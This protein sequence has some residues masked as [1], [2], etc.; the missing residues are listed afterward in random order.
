MRNTVFIL[1]TTVSVFAF[2][3]LGNFTALKDL[4]QD[5]NLK[6]IEYWSHE[7]GQA[8]LREGEQYEA[9]RLPHRGGWAVEARCREDMDVLFFVHACSRKWRR[10]AA[11]RDTLVEEAAARRFNWAAVFFV[12]RRA[13]EPL[14]DAWLNLEADALGDLVVFPL[15]DGYRTVTPKW[16]AG[17][18]WVAD[19][20]PN[21]PVIVKL[22][23]DV[24]VHPFKLSRYLQMEFPREPARL[25]CYVNFG[26]PVFRQ[27]GSRYFVRTNDAP[28]E[29]YFTYCSGQAVIMTFNVMR[30]LLRA[31]PKVHPHPTGVGHVDITHLYIYEAS[32]V[33]RNRSCFFVGNCIFMHWDAYKGKK[34][35]EEAVLTLDARV[36][37]SV[38]LGDRKV[39]CGRGA[40]L[41]IQA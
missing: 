1:V 5:E 40:G 34:R 16:V 9:T 20:C 33:V 41:I 30:T 39:Q 29:E 14:L 25:H 31:S 28:M 13:N 32:E 36:Y 23:D 37:W 19:R 4:L 27:P 24:T 11:L 8:A 17:M 2:S 38:L 7:V 26:Q 21:V 35:I 18:Q 12:G 22:D 6:H 15:E 3:Q 10:R